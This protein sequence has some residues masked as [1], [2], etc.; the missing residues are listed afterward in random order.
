M[1]VRASTP[2]EARWLTERTGYQPGGDFRGIV[3]ESG[4][5]IRGLVGFDRWT[6]NA[7][8]MHVAVDSPAGCRG[9]LRAAFGYA[10]LET[11]RTLVRGEVRASNVR[12]LALDKHLGFREVYRV[13]GGWAPG[14]DLILLEMRRDE[15]RW[16]GGS[17]G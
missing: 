8:S 17:H 14:E 7:V 6:P 13:E 5:A 9:L 16:I 1:R 2:D 11:G 10:F 15:C 4:G 3:A 12:A